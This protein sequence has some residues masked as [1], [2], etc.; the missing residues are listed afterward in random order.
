MS[1]IQAR[2]P[3]SNV[4]ANEMSG[5]DFAVLNLDPFTGQGLILPR[6]HRG[7]LVYHLGRSFPLRS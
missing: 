6:G 4:L 7:H 1:M 2:Y 5:S 3:P